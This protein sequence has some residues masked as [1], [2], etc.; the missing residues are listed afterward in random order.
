MFELPHAFGA[1]QARGLIRAVPKDFFV[2]EELGF[3]PGDG[4]EHLWLLIR[5]R[6][7]NTADLALWLARSAKLPLRAIG[8][9]GLKDKHAVTEQWFSLHLP[10]KPDPDGTQWPEGV[11]LLYSTRHTRKLN[12]GTHRFNFFALQ[13]R[14]IE[15]GEELA[16]RLE[17][18]ATRG[19]PNYFGEQRFGRELGNWQR[20]RAWLRGEGEAP[21]KPQLRSLWL[22][23][24]RSG[25]FN[26]VLAERV[27]RDCWDSLLA[28]DIC[29]PEGSRGLFFEHD[30][31]Q[32]QQRV[33]SGEVNPT[34][35]LVGNGG[36]SSLAEAALLEAQV[37]AEFSVEITALQS[38][39]LDALRRA[40]RIHVRDLSWQYQ[41]DT[42]QLEF[43]LPA[44]AFATSVLAELMTT[45]L[46]VRVESIQ[47]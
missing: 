38:E 5:K 24:V 23:A 15:Q 11:E 14:E 39:G 4:G 45:R 1:P 44:G 3:T 41:H 35:P 42:L 12:R 46:P 33:A 25:I 34:G 31:E 30:D 40:T 29:Q 32:A 22:S 13:V 37:M 6:G 21:R 7:W 20:G 16:A 9:S 19:V 10:G 43:R 27:R 26:A 8:Y 17:Q 18:I 36:L 28:G 47:Q 2:R